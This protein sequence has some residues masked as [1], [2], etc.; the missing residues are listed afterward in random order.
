[1]R[2]RG[3]LGTWGWAWRSGWAS[4]W[5]GRP[6]GW[7]PGSACDLSGLLLALPTYSSFVQNLSSS[8]FP[9]PLCPGALVTVTSAPASGRDIR[10]EANPRAG[11]TAAARF[12]E[13]SIARA[14]EDGWAP[15]SP[16]ETGLR[17]RSPAGTTSP[18]ATGRMEQD[19]LELQV[20]SPERPHLQ[21]WAQEA[22]LL[23][24]E[25]D[26]KALVSLASGMRLLRRRERA[27]DWGS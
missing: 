16:P 6:P 4:G 5:A 2:S 23:P 3:E 26:F 9:G 27:G 10:S 15:G 13:P 20:H 19:I 7:L 11:A 25:S 14:Q 22:A 21:K 17:A 24:D 1:M 18:R 8:G 12:P